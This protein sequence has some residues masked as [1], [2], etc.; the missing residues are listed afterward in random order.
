[1]EQEAAAYDVETL[2]A[3]PIAQ[4]PIQA[5]TGLYLLMG[6]DPSAEQKLIKMINNLKA[7]IYRFRHI[8]LSQEKMARRSNQDHILMVEAMKNH[9][10]DGVETL[11]RE[12]ILR[13]KAAVLKQLEPGNENNGKE[14]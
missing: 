2:K 14:F 7:Q 5:N 10:V 12:H 8:I 3:K 9:D 11:V 4:S 1:M 6:R 13:G